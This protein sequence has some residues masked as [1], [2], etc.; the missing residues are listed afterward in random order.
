MAS[1]YTKK[2]VLHIVAYDTKK[3]ART[4]AHIDRCVY[5]GRIEHGITV[6]Q[7]FCEC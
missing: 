3:D 7:G 4:G 6:W 5:L 1:Q 2:I